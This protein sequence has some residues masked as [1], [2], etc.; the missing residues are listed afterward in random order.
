MANPERTRELLVALLLLGVVF[1]APPLL[2]VFN[3]AVRIL[4]VPAL[5]LYL[6]A[7]WAV[8]IGLVALAAGRLA[9]SREFADDRPE[10]RRY[11]GPQG[12]DGTRDA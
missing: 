2:F 4:G 1:F 12:K 6:F 5:Y 3:K 11:D 10:P 7:A 8:L 9:D